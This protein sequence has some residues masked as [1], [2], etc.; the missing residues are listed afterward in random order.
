ML[1]HYAGI[2]L[3]IIACLG[4][5]ME[6][7][8]LTSFKLLY[9]LPIHILQLHKGGIPNMGRHT[10]GGGVGDPLFGDGSFPT[11]LSSRNH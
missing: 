11:G 2:I 7:E 10:R 1:M 3:R 6:Y 8:F 4:Y 9:P 5:K